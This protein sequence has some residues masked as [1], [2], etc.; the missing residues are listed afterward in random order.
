[1][2]KFFRWVF[3]IA[4]LCAAVPLA[5][6]IGASFFAQELEASVERLR[7]VNTPILLGMGVPLLVLSAWLLRRR[8]QSIRPAPRLKANRKPRNAEPPQVKLCENTLHEVGST[9]PDALVDFLNEN[10]QKMTDQTSPK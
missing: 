5:L 4:A 10:Y 9:L 8:W 1:M 3:R 2:M 7:L 6:I